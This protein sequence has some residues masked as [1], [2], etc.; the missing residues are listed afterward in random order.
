VLPEQ[1]RLTVPHYEPTDPLG[2]GL[3]FRAIDRAVNGIPIFRSQ[4]MNGSGSASTDSTSYVNLFGTFPIIK[5][6]GWTRLDVDLRLTW[7]SPTGASRVTIGLRLNGTDLDLASFYANPAAQHATLSSRS[8]IGEGLM[9]G[10]YTAQLR[11][12]VEGGDDDF[13]MD[14]NDAINL[15]VT[16]AI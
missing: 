8:F 15:T 12:K 10:T 13:S 3:N 4:Q 5:E 11:V 16:E 14:A 1:A 7:F 2:L 9:P 6:L